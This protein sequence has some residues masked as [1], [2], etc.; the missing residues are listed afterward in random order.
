VRL[1][2]RVSSLR[3]VDRSILCRPIKRH[4]R[5]H[6][7]DLDRRN[8][9]MRCR[10]TLGR[11]PHIC[12]FR[13]LQVG[14]VAL[15]LVSRGLSYVA[16]SNPARCGGTL[17]CAAHAMAVFRSA[18]PTARSLLIPDWDGRVSRCDTPRDGRQP[19]T[20]GVVDRRCRSD[21]RHVAVHASPHPLSLRRVGCWGTRYGNSLEL[22]AARMRVS[23]RICASLQG[24]C[25][26]RRD[27]TAI[28]VCE[29]TNRAHLTDHR[30]CLKCVGLEPHVQCGE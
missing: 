6:T 25:L 16:V 2:Y 30:P 19:H 13:A 3:S 14:R 27:Q 20:L 22:E 28:Q 10:S 5:W 17:D 21:A 4:R 26:V 15:D 9:D 11:A 24:G 29:I 18:D 8:Q 23:R 12:T 7:T 1:G